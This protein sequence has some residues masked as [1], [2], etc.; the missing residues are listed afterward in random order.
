MCSDVLCGSKRFHSMNN[1]EVYSDTETLAVRANFNEDKVKAV[2][3][4]LTQGTQRKLQ[5]QLTNKY[6]KMNVFDVCEN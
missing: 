2:L 4:S 1:K 5:R 3:S 6:F